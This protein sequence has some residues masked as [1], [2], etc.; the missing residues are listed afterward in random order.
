MS[1]HL[2]KVS[3]TA[4]LPAINPASGIDPNTNSR[5]LSVRMRLGC[6]G[7]TIAEGR[8]VGDGVGVFAGR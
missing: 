4:G 2:Q 8:D 1:T 5:G 7:E 3:A 6:D